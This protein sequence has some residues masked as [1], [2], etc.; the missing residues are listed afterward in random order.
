MFVSCLQLRIWTSGKINLKLTIVT[1]IQQSRDA[2]RMEE[3]SCYKIGRVVNK[4]RDFPA[5][6]EGVINKVPPTPPDPKIVV[7]YVS[8]QTVI[9]S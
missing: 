9:I 8:E 6:R 2:H 4:R 7:T 3:V 5:K 1:V